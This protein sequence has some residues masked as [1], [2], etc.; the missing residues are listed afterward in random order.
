MSKSII[1]HKRSYKIEGVVKLVNGEYFITT[2][3]KITVD[4]GK[5]FP[6]TVSGASI[7]KELAEICSLE[8]GQKIKTRACTDPSGKMVVSEIL[9]HEKSNMPR[10]KSI[11]TDTRSNPLHGHKGISVTFKGTID[12]ANN[13]IKAD[14]PISL[15]PSE[16]ISVLSSGVCFNENFAGAAE[17]EDGSRVKATAEQ[18]NNGNLKVTK[19]FAL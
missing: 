6:K 19:V 5:K 10:A 1:K 14:K 2:S 4:K 9:E 16:R 8:E 13:F 11:N 12:R 7:P 18:D 3:G 15:L 17:L